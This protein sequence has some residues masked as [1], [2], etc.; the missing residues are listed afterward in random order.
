MWRLKIGER[1]SNPL[2]RSPNGFFGREVW[3]FDPAAGTPEERAEVERLRREYTRNRFTHRECSDLLMRMQYTKQ[4]LHSTNLPSIKIDNDSEATG[5]TILAVL[6]RALSQ[7]SSLQGPDGHWPGGYSGIL[8]ILPLMIFA[9]HVTRSLHE[10]L[11]IE[12]IHE[13]CRYIYNIQ[14]ED[15][16]W[17]THT[18]GPSSMFGTCVNYA[19]LRILGEVLDGENDALSKGR[20]W[21][22]SHGTATA[23]PQWAKIYLSVV[24]AYDWSG[25]NAIIPELWMLPHFLP[26]HPGRFWCFCRMVYMPMAYIYGKKFVGPITPTILAI[27]NEIYNIPYN[28]IDWNKARNSCAKEDLIY[29][30]SW[31]QSVALAYLNNFVEPLSNLWPMNKLRE[32]AMSNLMEHIHYEDENSNYVGLCPINKV[33]NMICCWIEKPN[34]HEFRQH[35]PRIHDFLWIAEDGMKSK[36]YVGCQSWETALIVQAFCSTGL[37]EEFCSTLQKA[38]QFLQNAQITEDIP[39][40]KSYYRERTKGSWTLSNGENVWAIADTNAE[41]LK[42]ILLLSDI[43]SELVGNTIKQERLY[44]AI[45]CLLSFVNK[46]GTLSSAECKRTTS[47]VEF[48]NPSESFRNIIV[49]YPYPECTSSLIQVLILFRDKCPMYRREEIDK[50]IK[51]G[52]SFIEKVQRKDGSWYGSWAVCFTYATFFGIKG[53]ADAG[54]TYQNSLPIRKA[55]NFLL[56]KQLATGGWGES[57]LS[58]QTEEYVDSGRPHAVQTAQAML[59]LLYAGQVEQDPAPLY[60]A[61]KELIN[62]QMENGEFPQQEIVGNF[63]SSLFFN[64]PNFRNLFPI[65]ALGEFRRRLLAKKS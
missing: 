36:V 11:S 62:M 40:Y 21:I 39:N 46:D 1:P 31:L 52:A 12:H 22:L 6:R 56:S 58:C 2:L 15:G 35:L 29:R 54:R 59:A 38:H 27:R 4:N 44:D 47:W 9:L 28:E 25:N 24:G 23:A 60:R 19:T 30:R 45:D 20:A 55:C 8:F 7:F 63:N 37:T 16:G 34:S 33:L 10:V 41:A 65:W 43:P 5:E 49:D 32:R 26:I 17:G 13:I 61:A 53:L 57:Y 50:I 64:Y 14:N 48:I 3:E 51:S 42:A 18:L